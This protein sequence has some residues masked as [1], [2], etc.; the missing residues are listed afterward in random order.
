[1]ESLEQVDVPLNCEPGASTESAIVVT[2]SFDEYAKELSYRDN[3]LTEN[4]STINKIQS[5]CQDIENDATQI[6]S[7]SVEI[8]IQNNEHK[9]LPVE[10][11]SSVVISDD[12]LRNSEWLSKEKHIF[13]L[14]SAGK[15]IYA[16]YGNEEKLATTFGV[17]QALV[18]VIQSNND[19]VRSVRTKSTEFVFLVK[20]P[21]I[22]VAVSKTRESVSQIIL[23]LT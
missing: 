17:M 7:N 21:L 10:N 6:N 13:I 4:T 14:S 3:D 15:P 9:D 5:K 23:Q 18:S 2:D 16:R 22:L 8:T 12:Y 20:G 19:I 1:M 11:D